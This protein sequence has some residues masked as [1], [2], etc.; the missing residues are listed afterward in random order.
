MLVDKQISKW[1]STFTSGNLQKLT[2]LLFVLWGGISASTAQIT[3]CDLRISGVVLDEHS[4]KPM[5]YAGIELEESGLGA[6]TD[7][8]GRFVIND[9]C[10]GGIHIQI[11]HIGCETQ[12]IF[13]T[14]SH[15]TNIRIELDHDSHLLHEI[16]VKGHHAHD[17]VQENHSLNEENINLHSDNTLAGMLQSVT[18]VDQLRTGNTISKPV[19][20]GLYGNRLLIM[21]NG[22][23]QSGQQWGADH[24]PEIDPSQ[25]GRI[26]VIKGVSALQFQGNSLGSV[27]LIEP[28]S[29]GNDPHL[30][31]NVR[32]MI[33][34][35]GLGHGL[36][37]NTRRFN[38]QLSWQWTGSLKR[39]GDMHTPDHFLTNTGQS[40]ASSSLRLVHRGGEK[41]VNEL[42]LSTF[43][44][45]LGVLRGAHIGNTNDLQE[46]MIRE[47]PFYTSEDFSYGINA[48]FQRVNHH[49]AKLHSKFMSSSDRWVDITFSGQMNQRNEF[50]VRRGGRTD[51]PALSL[52]LNTSFAEIKYTD[53]RGEHWKLRSGMQYTRRQNRNVPKTGILPLIPDYNADQSG[54]YFLTEYRSDSLVLE[55]GVRYDYQDRRVA[56]I[57]SEFPREVIRYRDRFHNTGAAAG[58]HTDIGEHIGIAYNIG[59]ANRNPEVNELYS[60]GLHQG[61]SGYEIGTADMK[62]ERALKQ[63]LNVLFDDH[64]RFV[65]EVLGYYQLVNNYIFLNP[66][67]ELLLTIRGAFPIYRYRQTNASISGV[68]VAATYNLSTRSRLLVKYAYIHGTDRDQ[69]VALINL[70]SNNVSARW[71]YSIPKL[72]KLE[73]IQIQLADRYVFRQERIGHWQ[74]YLA[75][76]DA[77][78]LVSI[79]IQAEKQWKRDR[80]RFWLKGE[81]LLNTR[82]REYLNR[83]RYFSDETGINLVAGIQVSF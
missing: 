10:P 49:L 60:N 42:L 70:P 77:Y 18:G 32:Y 56:T 31:G 14:I 36:H 38:E 51:K 40:E 71:S 64:V 72:S 35:N 53:L 21:N 52:D 39:S 41:W 74:D 73:N 23:A 80:I 22:V 69:N 26:T 65:L 62:P 45:E 19:V 25:A 75:P 3:K 76:P 61:V 15:D 4:G 55:F 24:A 44:T 12:R 78:N 46:A 57:S 6:I 7:S 8:L 1:T 13:L 11:S 82:Y 48:P 28:S 54:G 37:F 29:I 59:Y 16:A 30:H 2:Y 27:V 67:N 47:E 68:D 63:T 81:N 50:D 20:H 33:R 83:L 79:R 5:E 66:E 17:G 43:N 9:I 58:I 34:S